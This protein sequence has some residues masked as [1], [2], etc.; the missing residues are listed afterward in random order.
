MKQLSHAVGLPD[1]ANIF[2]CAFINGFWTNIFRFL[3]V[4]K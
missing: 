3:A 1:D 4:S 2:P